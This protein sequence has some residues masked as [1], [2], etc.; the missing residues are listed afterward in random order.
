MPTFANV[1]EFDGVLMQINDCPLLL[2]TALSAASN[3][4][5]A[6]YPHTSPYYSSVVALGDVHVLIL[7]R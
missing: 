2:H 4:P 1:D 3:L 5:P 7:V 6:A